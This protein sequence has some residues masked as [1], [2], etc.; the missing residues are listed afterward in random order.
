MRTLATLTPLFLPPPLINNTAES[1]LAVQ[2]QERQEPVHYSPAKHGTVRA[3]IG[4]SD[5]GKFKEEYTAVLDHIEAFVE[6]H[7]DQLH[8]PLTSDTKNKVKAYLRI[9]KQHL[10][11]E[12]GKYFIFGADH[13]TEMYGTGKQWFH[14]LAKLLQDQGIQLQTRIDAV[15][16]LAPRLDVCAGGILS[17]L[18]GTIAALKSANCGLKGIAYRWKKQMMEALILEHVKA[19]HVYLVGE[20]IHYINAYYNELADLMGMQKALDPLV[21]ELMERNLNT[22]EKEITPEKLEACRDHLIKRLKL[23]PTQLAASIA[24]EY[25]GVIE[26]SLHKEKLAPDSIDIDE[27]YEK[28]RNTM[29]DLTSEYGEIPS[30]NLLEMNEDGTT[31]AYIGARQ[32]TRGTRH[33]LRALKNQG[34][35]HYDQQKTEG[36]KS[37]VVL[38]TIGED[39][40]KMLNDLLWR[41]EGKGKYGTIQELPES[42]LLRLDPGEFLDMFEQAGTNARERTLMLHDLVGRMH[43]SL[44]AAGGAAEPL[45]PWLSGFATKMREVAARQPSGEGPPWEPGWSDSVTL[46]AVTFDQEL[47]LRELL[48]AG[49]DKNVKNEK[50]RTAL[51]LAAEKGY[52]GVVKALIENGANKDEIKGK[53]PNIILWD[54]IWHTQEAIIEKLQ[55]FKNLGIDAIQISNAKGQSVLHLAAEDG[56]IDIVQALIANGAEIEAK[57]RYRRTPL[58]YAA[59]YGHIAVV[60]TLIENGAKEAK[61]RYRSTPLMFAVEYGH[62]AVVKA[63]IENG[64]EIEA[65]DGYGRT[66]L[67]LAAKCGHI[68]VVKALIANGANKDEIKE[69]LPNII[70]LDLIGHTQE[71]IIEKL[72]EFKNLG[73]DVIQIDNAGGQ[74]VLH[75]VAKDGHIEVVKALI[76]NGAEI[77]AEDEDG[78]TPLMLAAKKGHIEVV[79]ALIANGANQDEIKEKLLNII[80]LDLIG[81][82]QEEITEKLQE[83]KNLGIDARQVGNAQGYSVLHLA[84]QAVVKLQDFKNQG[85]DV[86]QID[87]KQFS[88][89]ERP[90]LKVCQALE[91]AEWSGESANILIS[92]L[93]EFGIDVNARDLL[94]RTPL[95]DAARNEALM[96]ELI[97]HGADVNA[98]M[99]DGYTPIFMALFDQHALDL[100]IQHGARPNH[101]NEDGLTPLRF[102]IRMPNL[103]PEIFQGL[104]KAGA[105]IDEKFRN[106]VIDKMRETHPNRARE[107][108]AVE[109][110]AAS[111]ISFFAAEA[112]LY[113]A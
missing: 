111:W 11:K 63:L 51:M 36:K 7:G 57:D 81:H 98:V 27:G 82:T 108:P 49:A 37:S 72:H 68:A 84:T 87:V 19:H 32:P 113:M 62:I 33:F 70:L 40:I 77:E 16:A 20:E 80:L 18:Q 61:D 66:P 24:D 29:K 23:K 93:I 95:F 8:E 91:K 53:L 5:F 54:L 75:L 17:D 10:F 26:D 86:Q 112:G 89:E 88:K 107:V 55:E 47:A 1:S 99:Q 30:N 74:S 78:R 109:A 46:L 69:E 90:T 25:R 83:F 28:V 38:G 97:R 56:H 21:D 76:A 85:I 73:I 48:K 67:M 13:R 4:S 106:E 58:M 104:I 31:M 79:K 3:F 65:K 12:N 59:K 34:L 43:T 64:A 92:S 110:D 14:E 101:Q 35:V 105:T 2:Q 71:A 94:Q 6:A 96:R 41:K 45:G 52:V 50:G 44:E 102:G 60:K 22:E 100:L 42:S 103:E 9:L 39:R 15:V